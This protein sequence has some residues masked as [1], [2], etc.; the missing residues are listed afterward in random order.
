MGRVKDY[1]VEAPEGSWNGLE[2]VAMITRDHRGKYWS[3]LLM[4]KGC[5]MLLWA[6]LTGR[7]GLLHVN[8]GD[9]GS[10]ARKSLLV[11]FGRMLGAPVF[12]HFH[13]VTFDRDIERLPAPARW[14]ARLPFRIATCNIVL[15][16]KWK[17]WLQRD[18]RIDK[19]PIE[20]LVNGVPVEPLVSR[21]HEQRAKIEILFLGNLIERKGVS[22][23]IHALSLIGEDAPHWQARLAGNGN[24]S[25]YTSLAE[26]AGVAERV[27]FNGWVGQDTAHSL[28]AQSDLL[29][30]PSYDE[31]LP[32]V[33]LEALGL[34]TPVITTPIGAIPE[35]LTDGRDVQFCQPGDREVLAATMRRLMQDAAL[36]QSLC[37]QGIATYREKFSVEAF[38]RNLLAI[39]SRYTLLQPHQDEIIA[40]RDAEQR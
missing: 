18:L 36:R 8:F 27:A 10:A 21:T 17:H 1:I 9:R 13:A 29:V 38:R 6:R 19:T 28:I 5:W 4:L 11:L 16:S 35:V 12:L 20:I 25:H 40:R 39:W 37:D 23:F 3:V 30:L 32:L 24:I 26:A 33:I 22:D 34:G 7:L 2:P 14:L 15:G 31:G